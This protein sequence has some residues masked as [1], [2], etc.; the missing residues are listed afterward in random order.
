M[1]VLYRWKPD[2]KTTR[3]NPYGVEVVAAPNK[4]HSGTYTVTQISS[5]WE[6]EKTQQSSACGN[7]TIPE[8]GL[9]LSASGDKRQALL[10]TFKVGDSITLEE[11]WFQQTTTPLSI[12][13]PTPQNNPLASGFPG[14]RASNQLILY[15]RDYGQSQTGTNEFGFEVTVQNGTVVAQEGF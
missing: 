14:Y 2:S 11:N 8:N 15:N 3:T 10:S 1:L 5:I 4:K 6:C 7:A 12:I 9:V 13:N